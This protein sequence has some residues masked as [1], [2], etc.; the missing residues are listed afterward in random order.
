MNTLELADE[1]CEGGDITREGEVSLLGPLERIPL[2]EGRRYRVG[3][4]DVAV[5]RTRTGDVYA[6]QA[7]C[8]HRRGP[9]ADGL[10][11]SGKV[12]CPLHGF[13]FDLA[14]GEPVQTQCASLRVYTVIV[15]PAGDLCILRAPTAL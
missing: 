15:T 12:V 7:D 3:S 2:G 13:T 6:V 11:G 4:E 10:I 9:L 5:F 14:T 8:P 1:L